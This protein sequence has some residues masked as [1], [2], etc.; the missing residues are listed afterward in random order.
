V[1]RFQNSV[2]GERET[3]I[4]F[5]QAEIFDQQQLRPIIVTTVPLISS[6]STVLSSTEPPRNVNRNIFSQCYDRIPTMAS[7]RLIDDELKEYMESTVFIDEEM[8]EDILSFWNKHR[9]MYPMLAKIARAVLAISASSS[10]VE[11]LFSAAKFTVSDRRSSLGTGK[12]N[13][14]IF[15]QKNLALL[16]ELERETNTQL[17]NV[18][19]KP[20]DDNVRSPLSPKRAKEHVVDEID[21][22]D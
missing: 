13:K 21:D 18:K 4:E 1:K 3:A 19:R 11:R 15:I 17:A 10:E 20:D 2:A 6:S 7:A 8:G 5:L 14:L 9:E 12:L 22:S 16:Q